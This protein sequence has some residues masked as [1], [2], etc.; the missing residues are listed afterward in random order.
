MRGVA[1]PG[2]QL[3]PG[4]ASALSAVMEGRVLLA[5][6]QGRSG[7]GR[8]DSDRRPSHSWDTTGLYPGALWGQLQG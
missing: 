6:T 2:G 7:L 1:C 3:G 4:Q 5:E 8:Q